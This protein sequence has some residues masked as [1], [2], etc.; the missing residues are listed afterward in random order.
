LR[1]IKKKTLP[2]YHNIGFQTISLYIFTALFQI[3]HTMLLYNISVAAFILL[4]MT[5]THATT[6]EA[7]RS[8]HISLPVAENMGTVGKYKIVPV[9]WMGQ[10]TPGGVNTTISATSFQQ[11][12]EYLEK[13]HP[14]A[15]K[16]ASRARSEKR[17]LEKRY[18]S[19]HGQSIV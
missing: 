7:H 11:I 3:F 9:S 10:L 12:Y 18:P 2:L 6:T 19:V 8:N 5:F 15:I 17:G 16:K 13:N 4:G 1:T 14:H